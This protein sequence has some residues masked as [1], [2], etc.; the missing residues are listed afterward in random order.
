MSERTTATKCFFVS[1]IALFSIGCGGSELAGEGTE[2]ATESRTVS[3]QP[4]ADASE[5]AGKLLD[6][7]D[8]RRR[9][10]GALERKLS[11][12]ARRVPAALEPPSR[13]M[14]QAIPRFE[15]AQRAQAERDLAPDGDF[16]LLQLSGT[17]ILVNDPALDTGG[18]TQ[19]ETSVVAVGSTVCTAFN[20]AGEGFFANGGSGHAVSTDGGL[21][22]TDG[23]PFPIG[24][25]GDNNFGDPSLAYSVRDDTFYYAALSSVGLSIWQSSN[26]CQTFDYVAPIHVG[27]LD[28]KELIAVDNTPASPYFGRIHV[29]WT[30]FAISSNVASF[31]DDGGVTWSAPTPLPGS[32]FAGQGVWPAVAPNGDVY[33]ALV[34]RS[35]EIGG[36]QDQWIWRST[37]GGATWVQMTDIGTDQLQPENVDNTISCG[38]QALRGDIRNLSSPQI[39]I[40]PDAGAPAGYVIHTV[41]PYDSDG[42]VGPDNSNVFYRRSDDGAV[43]WSAEVQLNDDLTFTDQFFPA[44]GVSETGVLVASWYDR[45][46]DP[47]DNLLFDRFATFSMDGGQTWA[48]NER[49]SDVSSPV[50]QT[51]PNFDGLATCYHGDYDQVAVQGSLAHIVWSDDRRITATGPDPDIYYDQLVINP[52][53]GRLTADRVAVS[54]TGSINFTLVDADIAGA[55]TQAIALETSGGDSETLVLTED[56]GRPGVFLGSINTAPGAAVP[57]SGVL[58]IADGQ[59]ITAT[60]ND[61]DDGSGSPAVATDEIDTDCVGPVISN[62]RVTELFGRLARVAI[63]ASEPATL[64]VDFGFSCAALDQST[65]SGTLSVTPSVLLSPLFPGVTYFYTVAAT[66]QFGN[67]T[68]DDNGGNCYTFTTLEQIFVEDFE[69]GLGDFVIDNDF[70]RGNGLWHLSTACA[71]STV[72]GHSVPSTLY[73]GQDETCDYD[74]G[75]PNSGV[76]LSPVIH[77]DDASFATIEFN[78]FLGTEGGG[79]FDQAALEISVNGGDFQVADSNFMNIFYTRQPPNIRRR[80]GAVAAPRGFELLEN[81]GFWQHAIVNVAPLL[82]GLTEADI[83]LRFRFDSVDAVANDFAGFYVDD[84]ELFGVVPPE[85]C[86][87]S[88]SCDDGLFCNGVELCVEGFCQSSPPVTCSGDDGVSCTDFVCDEA[89]DSCVHRPNDANCDDGLG[90]NGLERCDAVSGCLPGEPVVCESD[91]V[92]CT[93][94]ECTELLKGCDSVPNSDLCNDGLFCTGFEFCD[95]IADCQPGFPPCEDNQSCTT[96][97]CDEA[98]Q[99][100]TWISDDTQC[101]DDGLFCNGTESCQPFSGCVNSG[102]PCVD[103]EVCDEDEDQCIDCSTDTSPP[104]FTFVPA[105]VTTTACGSFDIGFAVAIDECDVSVTNNAPAQFP[106]GTTIVTWIATD[107]AGNVRTATQRVTVILT[108]NSACCPAGTNV[109]V[110]TSNNNTLTG[111]NGSD[112]ILGLG[113]QDTINGLGGV[114]YISGGDGNDT[115]NAGDGND[116]VFG[117]SA[118]DN[119]SG[120][121]GADTMFGDDGDDIVNGGAGNDTLHGGQGQ[122]QLNGQDNNDTLFG[123]SGD[124]TLSGG[125]GNDNLVGGTN[126]DNC[127]GGTGVNT[128]A[129]CEFGAPN[130]CTSG[131]QNGTETD[132]DCGGGCSDCGAGEGCISGSDCQGGLFCVGN[133]CT[134]SPF[135]GTSPLS[136]E[137]NVTTDWG[138]GYCGDLH[139]T[140]N[141]ATPATSFEILLDLNST[142]IFTLWNGTFDFPSGIVTVD[143]V[144]WNSS[145]APSATNSTIGFCANRGGIPGALPIVLET[146]GTFSP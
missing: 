95:A 134:A 45:R 4:I 78:Y 125:N 94:D 123:D 103:P 139:V 26:G 118:G 129:Q 51:N 74:N 108:N 107:F 86:T 119:L 85:A 52:S 38:R 146:T 41:Y 72:A 141:A 23:G 81:T 62:V 79:F 30:D 65:A 128:F 73:Y 88:G 84:V 117:G 3:D 47:T 115:V 91:G 121:N 102:D 14:L 5:Q 110:G 46:L 58:E 59:T 39:V 67:T 101:P 77:L 53:L 11:Y 82:T 1:F 122:D 18:T 112:C 97:V 56:S 54:C 93:V 132:V 29:G 100:C 120:G 106:P 96:D 87:A 114:D 109:I 42:A 116:V 12:L 31:S 70:E 140:N 105:D 142:S 137:F 60:Y 43:T 111:T 48:E 143:P 76:A 35:F 83:Q 50:A 135:G 124:D 7:P 9:M 25:G 8:L 15:E 130:S 69:D 75:L 55:G 99:T 57:G 19:S 89:T 92:S 40:S 104:E 71:S 2:K 98:T 32:G 133:S 24:P 145:I 66:D 21:S 6:D 136:T 44:I 90:C 127:N 68:E 126:N 80:T 17:D 64:S 27:F 22:F 49:I 61:A 131:T 10:S 113:G 28:D 36:L 144:G 37:D 20:D 33:M 63:D 13:E 34:N 16:R 138:S